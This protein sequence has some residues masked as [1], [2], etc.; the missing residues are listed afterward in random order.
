MRLRSLAVAAGLLSAGC[1]A[2]GGDPL[3]RPED[4]AGWVNEA[5]ALGVYSNAHEPLGVANGAF[6]YVDP[7]CPATADDGTLFVVT[8]DCQDARGRT[9]AGEVT[10]TRGEGSWRLDFDGFGDDRF[11]GM[12]ALSGSFTIEEQGE[13]LHAFEADL[14]RDGGI[15]TRIRYSGTVAGGYDRETVWNGAGTVTRR[16]VTINSGSVHAETV[17]QRRDDEVCAGEGLS[18]TTSMT[19]EEHT[20]VVTYDGAT[21]CDDDDAA[22]WSLDGADQGLVTGVTCSAAGP[23][24]TGPALLLLL[25]LAL[26]TP[27]RR[28]DPS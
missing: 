20:V 23:A 25:A 28:P 2:E 22:R 6:T 4:I 26:L 15:V 21:D 27:R 13:D 17:D 3:E 12:A 1:A 24:G 14:E 16:G 7:A 9:W 11:G 8:G 10:V 5:S 18:G 19:S